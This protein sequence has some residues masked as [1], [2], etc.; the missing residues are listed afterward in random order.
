MTLPVKFL[1][2]AAREQA[3]AEMSADQLV[4]FPEE[5]ESRLR[6]C[7]Y[8]QDNCRQPGFTYL[9]TDYDK[10]IIIAAAPNLGPKQLAVYAG[11]SFKKGEIVGEIKGIDL[12]GIGTNIEI[13]RM[14]KEY[15]GNSTFVWK[16]NLDDQDEYAVVIDL[17]EAGTSTRWVNHAK[18]PNLEVKVICH[19][20]Q[21]E[22][23]NIQFDYHAY[24]V[25]TRR[26]AFADELT[27]SYGDDYFTKARPQILRQPQTLVQVLY[28]LAKTQDQELTT[29][30]MSTREEIKE[31]FSLLTVRAGM[32]KKEAKK[33]M[34]L[35][36]NLDPKIYDLHQS[37]DV[38]RFQKNQK[39]ELQRK[40]PY[41]LVI[42]PTERG[43]GEYR[44]SLFS[45]QK[46]PAKKPLCELIGEQRDDVPK[47]SSEMNLWAMREGIDTNYLVQSSRGGYLYTKE[48]ASEA[49]C[50]EGA[51][52]IHEANVRFDFKTNTY[53]TTREIQSGEEILAFYEVYDYSA[54]PT[55]LSQVV[56]DFN[57]SQ[58]Y[59]HAT[60]GEAGINLEY[61]IPKTPGY[62]LDEFVELILSAEKE[63]EDEWALT[64]CSD[65]DENEKILTPGFN[66]DAA[67]QEY[68]QC[69]E[70]EEEY[71]QS[72]EEEEEYPQG[73]EEEEHSKREESGFERMRST[74]SPAFQFSGNSNKKKRK[75][76]EVT[77][78]EN[79]KGPG[80]TTTYS[81]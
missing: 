35:D 1:N 5:S 6:L 28:D 55:T 47:R 52:Q 33:Q 21:D 43:K 4:F 74:W 30:T 8:L 10:D 27:I 45:A 25:A 39:M 50:I 48:K 51:K 37:E 14:V 72:L 7:H 29:R 70:E 73:L 2:G 44:Y 68:P 22:F 24:Y 12:F 18:K 71:P 79:E 58:Y 69:L 59:Y 49:Y 9:S 41:H 19:Q 23:G 34:Y 17:L 11:K 80:N 77:V 67:E 40:S 60:W 65:F 46:I 76:T 42:A 57:E 36:K 56:A 78:D 75:Y 66:F 16:L 3:V 13:D 32:R 15:Q 31:F 20:Q 81:I 62:N 63:Q 53:I 64:F 26:I 38:A 54:S 61:V